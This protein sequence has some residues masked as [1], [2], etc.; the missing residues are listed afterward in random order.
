MYFIIFVF[1]MDRKEQDNIYI[2]RC[3][4]LARMG[5]GHTRSNPM[6]GAVIVFDNRIIGEGYHQKYGQAHAEVNAINSVKDKQLL[7]KST[8]YVSLEPCSHH[9]KTPPCSDL[10]IEKKIPRVVIGAT[11]TNDMVGGKGV[12]KLINAGL[13]VRVGVLERECR[14][15]NS[16]FYTFHEKQRPYVILK[17][18]QTI[19]GFIDKE[20]SPTEDAHV[21]WITSKTSRMLVHKWRSEEMAIMVGKNTVLKDNPSLTVRDWNGT[22]PTRIILDKNLELP[23]DKAVFDNSATTI[24]FNLV[25]NKIEDNIEFIKI[26]SGNKALDD[27]LKALHG[28]GVVSLFVEGGAN[29]LQSFIDKNIWDE[30]RVFI[31]NKYFKNGLTAPEIKQDCFNQHLFNEDELKIF[32]NNLK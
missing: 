16:R 11:D 19:D 10:I 28:K 7:E 26:E 14:E 12:A 4:E 13:D 22:Q 32:K 27:I 1:Y 8:I 6:V 21:N 24:V 9:G 20:R 5:I 30:A 15:L 23:R 17:W 25:K 31:G 2:R 3:L 29:L 18:A